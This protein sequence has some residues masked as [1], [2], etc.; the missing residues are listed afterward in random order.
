MFTTILIVVTPAKQHLKGERAYSGSQLKGT[1]SIMAGRNGSRS[2]MW[3][4]SCVPSQEEEAD[5]YKISKAVIPSG[6]LPPVR[7]H[8]LKIPELPNQHQCDCLNEKCPHQWS[9]VFKHLVANQ[10]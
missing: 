9:Q 2:G 1:K 10:W 6:S 3:L 4:L 7:L 5:S 8:L